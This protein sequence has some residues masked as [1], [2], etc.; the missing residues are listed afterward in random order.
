MPSCITSL[1]TGVNREPL[2]ATMHGRPYAPGTGHDGS[3]DSAP[4]AMMSSGSGQERLRRSGPFT[5]SGCK[6]AGA[7]MVN[8]PPSSAVLER[9][10]RYLRNPFASGFLLARQRKH[11]MSMLL[12]TASRLLFLHPIRNDPV[13]WH[14]TLQ[15]A[16]A[17]SRSFLHWTSLCTVMDGP[18]TQRTSRPDKHEG[19][20]SFF[21]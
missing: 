7:C 6:C 19:E 4:K 12:R 11:P 17:C 2:C 18:D 13:V 21:F 9:L 16:H 14:C 8:F 20:S 3:L 15:Q 5:T 10:L 1:A